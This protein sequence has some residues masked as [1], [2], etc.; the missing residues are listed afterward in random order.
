MTPK[1]IWTPYLHFINVWVLFTLK[2][3]Q[4]VYM[5]FWLSIKCII[6]LL[7]IHSSWL[8]CVSQPS[9]YSATALAA[10]L[11]FL[12]SFPALWFFH[13]CGLC[14]VLKVA[15]SLGRFA[16][17]E[18]LQFR[19]LKS[20]KPEALR[21]SCLAGRACFQ[22]TECKHMNL[23]SRVGALCLQTARQGWYMLWCMWKT[24]FLST[25]YL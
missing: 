8:N 20:I 2:V 24:W 5:L 4:I 6:L 23:S 19:R 7:I 10:S 21:K 9:V 16:K 25:K 15:S 17:T 14:R 12:S 13:L 22:I 1:S 11:R 18:R 3:I